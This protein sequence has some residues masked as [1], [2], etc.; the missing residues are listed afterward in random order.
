V[1][2]WHH[3][4][5]SPSGDA[6]QIHN[7]INQFG[8]TGKE[9]YV[10]EWG[11]YLGGYEKHENA[12]TYAKYLMDHSLASGSYIDSSAI[13]SLYDWGVSGCT[14]PLC[15][16]PGLITGSAKTKTQSYYAFRMITRAFQG[17]KTIYP[18][19]G[20]PQDSAIVLAATKDSSNL[21]V[22][23]LNNGTKTYSMS[24]DVSAHASSGTY[25]L[26]KFSSTN[27]DEI[28]G[29]GPVS[30][31]IVSFGSSPGT[32]MQVIIPISGSTT[33]SSTVQSTTT[34]SI[35]S[36]T[37]TSSTTMQ[38]T[39]TTTSTL[40][41]C[42]SSPPIGLTVGTNSM[43]F[44]TLHPYSNN[45]DCYS[46]VYEC[47][48]GYSARIHTRYDTESWYDYL[49]VY[50]NAT[51]N[52]TLF[53]GNSSGYVWIDP[54]YSSV[55]FRFKSDGSIVRW[56]VDVDI[57]DCYLPATTSSTTISPS[58]STTDGSTTTSSS[59]STSGPSTT[60]T[61]TT[62]STGST[63][64]TLSG[65]CTMKSNK[66]PC[67]EVALSEVVNAITQWVSGNLDLGQVI[68]LLNSWADPL[69]Y[70]PQ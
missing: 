23:V 8:L 13:F 4:V 10:S 27:N 48:D 67:G 43:V 26:R 44:Q 18:L 16:M 1:V 63:S 34:S 35:S 6:A 5:G 42:Y 9:L 21:Y 2:D 59:T 41:S 64:T 45:I 68:D 19:V 29:T 62:L 70:P 51:G 56:G 15:Y 14:T 30:G 12:M 33:T 11:S 22:T 25:T 54:G 37:T 60:T 58:S 38:A 40:P 47:P 31:G 32:I 66:P 39:T 24:L 55:G 53:T 61:T 3:Y 49:Y 7:W 52:A 36:S 57:I 69:R 20:A 46:G 50:D 65:P 17:G 28:T